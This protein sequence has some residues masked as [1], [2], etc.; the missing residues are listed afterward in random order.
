MK[1]DRGARVAW[2]LKRF[3]RE[4][5]THVW[6]EGHEE[7]NKLGRSYAINGRT[8]SHTYA[9]TACYECYIHTSDTPQVSCAQLRVVATRQRPD[10]RRLMRVALHI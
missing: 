6:E 5:F 9:R 10:I 4:W 3:C 2:E 8:R 7:V 1:Q